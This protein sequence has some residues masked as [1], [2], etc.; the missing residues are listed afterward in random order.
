MQRVDLDLLDFDGTLTP[1]AGNLL[2]FSDHYRMVCTT[3]DLQ[4]RIK[5]AIA[6]ME[7]EYKESLYDEELER[8]IADLAEWTKRIEDLEDYFD[9]IHDIMQWDDVMINQFSDEIAKLKAEYIGSIDQ[10]ELSDYELRESLDPEDRA[11]TPGTPAPDNAHENIDNLPVL[12]DLLRSLQS[13]KIELTLHH[14]LLKTEFEHNIKGIIYHEMEAITDYDKPD[15]IVI[16]ERAK[17]IL[18]NI[19][20]HYP[21]HPDFLMPEDAVKYLKNKLKNADCR[22]HII[23]KNH[24][25]YIHA[26]LRHNG[27][28]DEEIKQLD[29]HDLRRDGGNKYACTESILSEYRREA[30]IIRFTIICDDNKQDLDAMEEAANDGGIQKSEMKCFHAAPGKFDFRNIAKAGKESPAKASESKQTVFKRESTETALE[31]E[32]PRKSSRPNGQNNKC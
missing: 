19:K 31:I 5:D 16:A 23:S 21:H 12:Q 10:W 29:I 2:V 4:S 9:S 18:H 1:V 6:T 7:E 27:F 3:P 25:E 32:S 20:K 17:N 22:I 14:H 30:I 26:V 24:Q 15:E 11:T 8:L 13:K 28:T